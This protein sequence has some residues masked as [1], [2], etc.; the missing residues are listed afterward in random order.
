MKLVA[1]NPNATVSMTRK[2]VAAAQAALPPAVRVEGRT[3]HESP[4]AIETPQDKAAAL[5]HVVA[6]A[7]AAEA[8]GAAACIIACFD[9][10][11]LDEA[12]AAVSIPVVGIGEAA[13]HAAALLGR[14][15]SI[16]TTTPEAVPGMRRNLADYGLGGHC[17][18]V[19]AC[20][21]RV[22]DLERPGSGARDRVSAEIAAAVAEDGAGTVALG[23]AGMA[24]L[25]AALAAEHG[26]T[27]IDGIRVAAQLAVIL[28]GLSRAC[29]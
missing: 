29:G 10:P 4:P 24:D 3:C 12:R 5:P 28:A 23:C 26:I 1:I 13:F 16:V 2:I 17:A 15:W 20:D 6:A 22:L 27:V 25:A 19:R 8:E 9:D 21:I 7:K 11:G 14:P 18:N